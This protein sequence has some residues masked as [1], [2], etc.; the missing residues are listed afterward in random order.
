MDEKS[1]QQGQNVYAIIFTVIAVLA[2]IGLVLM[3]FLRVQADDTGQQVA[4]ASAP[5]IDSATL[6]DL[7]DEVGGIENA[8]TDTIL[9]SYVTGD[10]TEVNPAIMT[11]NSQNHLWFEFDASDQDGC[12]EIDEAID[13]T[14]AMRR[15]EA[16]A[17]VAAGDKDAASC[18]PVEPTTSFDF[19][20]TCTGPGDY[21]LSVAVNPYADGPLDFGMYYFAEPTD[22]GTVFES[23]KWEVFTDLTDESASLLNTSATVTF[24]VNS[25]NALD[26][27]AL[28]D[29]GTVLVGS[30]PS[31]TEQVVTF[32]N[33]GNRAMDIDFLADGDLVCDGSG[34]NNIPA[35]NVYIGSLPAFAN[36]Q[37]GGTE[38]NVFASGNQALAY[39]ELDASAA[40][41]VYA[42]EN[43]ISANVGTAVWDTLGIGGAVDTLAGTQSAFT[44]IYVQDSGQTGNISGTCSNIVTFSA[45]LAG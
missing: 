36:G 44:H 37:E 6:Y 5:S 20:S 23:V 2:L 8:G 30:L 4:T 15:Q 10:T 14:M 39:Q 12:E 24:E 38:E 41:D 33:T 9:S 17:C 42:D 45:D 31:T 35:D 32:I 18:Y 27:D 21:D 19:G 16:A 43:E 11:E 29:Y 34:S 1:S 25:L 22:A 40:D 13:Y 7:A 28:I 3:L 26:V